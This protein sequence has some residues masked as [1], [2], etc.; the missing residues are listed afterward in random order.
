MASLASGVQVGAGKNPF[1][2]SAFHP[3]QHFWRRVGYECV[4]RDQGDIG[5]GG[6]DVGND[7]GGENHDAFAGELREQVAETHAFFGVE[8]RRWLVDDEQLRIVQQCLRDTDALLH[9]PGIAAQRALADAR[10][11]YEVQKFVDPLLG[12]RSVEAFNGGE[13]FEK[14]NS[15]QVG[16]YAE[17]V[18]KISECGAQIVGVGCEVGTIPNDAAFCSAGY[19]G[20]DAHERR[21]TGAVGP[22]QS[23]CAGTELQG[24]I[25][26]GPVSGAV[27]LADVFDR[28]L[29]EASER[30]L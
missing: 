24:E 9:P 22:E 18:R 6:L 16:I 19:G 8:S 26:Q 15:V 7:V 11:V 10:Q 25:A 23:Q 28:E 12:Q 5:R 14:L 1:P 21:L 13:I 27:A 2:H 17:V 4:L 20:E 29:Q 30:S 3:V